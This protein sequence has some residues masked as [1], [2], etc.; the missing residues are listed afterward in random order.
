MAVVRA[1]HL[2]HEGGLDFVS[3][4]C[5]LDERQGSVH[6][7]LGGPSSGQSDSRNH[8]GSDQGNRV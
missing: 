6:G 7:D 2:D 8:V 3:R 1:R 5:V 4:L